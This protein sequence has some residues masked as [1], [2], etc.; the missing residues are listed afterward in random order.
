MS[1]VTFIAVPI[2]VPA[3]TMQ[4]RRL[5]FF[6][7]RGLTG[8]I[9]CSLCSLL[10]YCSIWGRWIVSNSA[11][12]HVCL[13]WGVKRSI[14]LPCKCKRLRNVWCYEIGQLVILIA[15]CPQHQ[16]F[17]YRPHVCFNNTVKSGQTQSTAPLLITCGVV[18]S[19]KP[20]T[21]YLLLIYW[22]NNYLR[23]TLFYILV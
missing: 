10:L 18:K 20:C 1:G 4:Q 12:I 3:A 7:F 19:I 15:L 23:Y 14:Y 16:C 5:L 13:H 17:Y 9:Y 2:C 8:Y 21:F 6:I 11:L 22:T